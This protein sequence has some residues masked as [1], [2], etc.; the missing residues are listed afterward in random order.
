MIDPAK[1]RVVCSAIRNVHGS[2]ICSARHFDGLMHSQ[3]ATSSQDGW[4]QAEQ[5]FIDQRGVFLTRAQALTVALG[6][7]QVIRRVG[8]D[9]RALYSENLY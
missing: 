9:E 2:I 5:G 4:K 1:Q 6:A 3:I 8:G 7:G